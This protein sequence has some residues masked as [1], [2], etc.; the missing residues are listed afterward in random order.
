M[1]AADRFLPEPFVHRGRRLSFSHG[2]VVLAILA[3]ALLVIFDGITDALIPLFA[4]GALSAFTTS[5]IGMVAHW[6]KEK[7][8][9]AT[10]A[11]VLNGIGAMA[12]GATL[13]V[14]ILTKFREGA[15][16]TVALV[17]S[18]YVLFKRVRAHYDF[19][20][21]ATATSQS[22]AMGPPRQA[23][24]VVPMR[25][26]DAV[27]L[28]AMWFGIGFAERVIAVQVLTG[29]REV[30]DL[31]DRWNELAVD[32]SRVETRTPPELVVLRSEY[33]R[34]YEPLLEFVRQLEQDHPDRPIAVIVP[35]LVEPRWYHHFLHNHTA[36]MMKALLLFR[37]GPQTVIISTPFYLRD[38]RPER[39]WLRSMRPARRP[40][41]RI[42]RYAKASPRR[43]TS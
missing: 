7:G 37:G 8:H 15:W 11:M 33:R 28:K 5:Q 43:P 24:A 13:V 3:A 14:V 22:L 18:M 38:W 25:R 41:S 34:L 21:Q 10:R 30:D 16:I 26:W 2:I 19:I 6:R 17:A 4:I 9:R 35:E 1:L 27:S 32:P 23:I 39:S 31:T 36:S 42:A 29:D 40:K 20:A 12:T